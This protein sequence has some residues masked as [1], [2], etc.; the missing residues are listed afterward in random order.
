[1][2]VNSIKSASKLAITISLIALAGCA[3]DGGLT[4]AATVGAL[5]F[6]PMPADIDPD[7]VTAAVGVGAVAFAAPLLDTDSYAT[8][9]DGSVIAEPTAAS[10]SGV[11]HSP[12]VKPVLVPEISSIDSLAA[13]PKASRSLAADNLG[14]ALESLSPELVKALG[15]N[16]TN[17][18]WV[19]SVTP[20]S[21]AA[22]AGL[23]PMDVIQDLS[24]QLINEP[25]DFIAIAGKLRSGY[26]AP[27]S[28][29]RNRA[30]HELILAI[31]AGLSTSVVNSGAV[32]AAPT[33]PANSATAAS[34]AQQ[35][36]TPTGAMYCTAVLATQH[37]YGATASPV[38]L[39]AGAASDMKPS[40]KSYIAKVKQEQ[41]S[42]WG[43]FKFNTTICAPGAVVC[44]AEAEGPTGKTQNA[45]EFCHATQAK[46]DA[47]LNQMRQGDPQTV[48]VD[49]P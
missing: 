40:L 29:W 41:P 27:L 10:S 48:V 39:I 9:P 4:E 36:A 45:F 15:L 17:G 43:E 38:K 7:L 31:P 32:A 25:N 30:N 1:M 8:A 28:V 22:K 19:V 49:W 26:K 44:M 24:G 16:D 37:T 14:L 21:P 5:M 13:A 34:P 6:I 35:S 11:T 20:G 18:A 47:E 2:F 3:S 33:V 42:V 23:K 46:A 12:V